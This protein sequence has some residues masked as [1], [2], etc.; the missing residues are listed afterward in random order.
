MAMMRE[1]TAGWLSLFLFS[2]SWSTFGRCSCLCLSVSL[3]IQSDGYFKK[4]IFLLF[5]SMPSALSLNLPLPFIFPFRSSL[6]LLISLFP[7][8]RPSF[9]PCLCYECV[10]DGLCVLSPW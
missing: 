7:S 8:F 10:M 1:F 5:N 3:S 6:S 4:G 9:L 2:C